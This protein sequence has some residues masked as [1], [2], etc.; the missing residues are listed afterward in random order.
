MILLIWGHSLIPGEYSASES[1]FITS[2]ITNFLNISGEGTDHIVRKC[3]HFFEYM[4]LGILVSA[5]S[6]IFAKRTVGAAS[7][8]PGFFVPLTDETIQ[9]FI[10]DRGGMIFDVWLDFSGY[11]TGIVCFAIIYRIIK[12]KKVINTKTA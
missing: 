1:G 12:G 9:L 2:L 11:V 4:V 5:D 3:A 10:P 7:V 8:L 6:V